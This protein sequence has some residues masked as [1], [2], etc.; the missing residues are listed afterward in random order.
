MHD[1]IAEKGKKEPAVRFIYIVGCSK[2]YCDPYGRGISLDAS[3]IL[4]E[5]TAKQLERMID[6]DPTIM[7][8]LVEREY[9]EKIL[10]DASEWTTESSLRPQYERWDAT[11]TRMYVQKEGGEQGFHEENVHIIKKEKTPDKDRTL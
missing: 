9:K 2:D 11:G 6:K 7:R 1:E 10:K 8:R 4:P 3:F 5:S